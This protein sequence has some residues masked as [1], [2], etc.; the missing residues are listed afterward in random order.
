VAPIEVLFQ[1]ALAL[2]DSMMMVFQLLAS[3]VIL[4]V[5]VAQMVHLV[6]LVALLIF[7]C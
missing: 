3:L 5:K 1:H 7:G 4:L 6:I 2:K